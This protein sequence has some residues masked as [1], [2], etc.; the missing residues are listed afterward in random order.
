M[1]L[2]RCAPPRAAAGVGLPAAVA[3]AALGG[4]SFLA[5]CFRH[6]PPHSA[7]AAAGAGAAAAAPYT[8]TPSA[9]FATAAASAEPLSMDAWD[10]STSWA[11]LG[12]AAG[13]G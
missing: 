5:A 2:A 10:P 12:V 1:L 11:D 9:C 4:A 3:A 6:V 7:A 8:I 13:K